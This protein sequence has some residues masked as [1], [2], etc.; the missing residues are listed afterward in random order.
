MIL[1]GSKT[2]H[3]KSQFYSFPLLV[4]QE[5]RKKSVKHDQTRLTKRLLRAIT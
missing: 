1:M 3:S 5:P 2:F 4:T